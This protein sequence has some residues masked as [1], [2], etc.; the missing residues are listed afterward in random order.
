MDDPKTRTR[1]ATEWPASV[2]LKY[3]GMTTQD[4]MTSIA[5]HCFLPAQY[6]NYIFIFQQVALN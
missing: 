4:D 3:C 6:F 5:F 1:Q 2:N